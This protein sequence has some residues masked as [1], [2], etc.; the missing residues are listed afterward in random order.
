[1]K[2]FLAF[3]QDVKKRLR[4]ISEQVKKSQ[5]EGKCKAGFD[6][7]MIVGVSDETDKQIIETSDWLYHELNAR[8]VYYSKFEPIKNTPLENKKPEN[9]LREY[10]LYQASFLLRDYDFHPKDFVFDDNDRLDLKQDPKLVIAKKKELLI[11]VNEAEFE[12]LIKVPGIGLKTAQ[13]IIE[14]RPI[15]NYSILKSLGVILNR[16][17]PFIEISNIRQISL[18]NWMTN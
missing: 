8:R 7:Q 2:L 12:E 9:P 1:M 10:R 17:H 15:K 18:S 4:W 14:N 16:A 5:K 6:S 3:V 13:K 11:D